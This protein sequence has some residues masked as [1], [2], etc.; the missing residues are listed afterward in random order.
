[1]ILCQFSPEKPCQGAQLTLEPRIMMIK[2]HG[3]KSIKNSQFILTSR[4]LSNLIVVTCFLTALSL[5]ARF[6]VGRSD[7]KATTF[8]G[9][10]SLNPDKIIDWNSEDE[11]IIEHQKNR[12]FATDIVLEEEFKLPKYSVPDLLYPVSFVEVDGLLKYSKKNNSLGLFLIPVGTGEPVYRIP[13]EARSKFDL[14]DSNGNPIDGTRRTVTAEEWNENTQR[15]AEELRAEAP[16]LTLASF[17]ETVLKIDQE[18][19]NEQNGTN[20]NQDLFDQIA[21]SLRVKIEATGG[22]GFTEEF[23]V[24]R[25]G[26][27]VVKGAYDEVVEELEL[28]DR[29]SEEKLDLSIAVQLANLQQR[30]GFTN[31]QKVIFDEVAVQLKTNVLEFQAANPA[32]DVDQ[33]NVEN[34][35]VKFC[36][37]KYVGDAQENNR[38]TCTNFAYELGWGIQSYMP[39]SYAN[40][41]KWSYQYALRN[42]RF[43]EDE[44]WE[45]VW[46]KQQQVEEPNPSEIGVKVVDRILRQSYYKDA[47]LDDTRNIYA[48]VGHTS[49]QEAI[50]KKLSD[51]TGVKVQTSIH[52]VSAY[53]GANGYTR[54]GFLEGGE[55]NN[56]YTATVKGVDQEA[57]N[58]NSKIW[59][60]LY[61][62]NPESYNF[63][64]NYE[65]DEFENVTLHRVFDFARGW[66]DTEWVNRPLNAAYKK[67]ATQLNMNLTAEQLSEV[68]KRPYYR[69]LQD[70]PIFGLY[71]F[72]GVTNQLNVALNVPL[73]R[74]YL[75]KI[76]GSD[77][78]EKIFTKA[79][80]RW[81]FILKKE[82]IPEEVLPQ[83]DLSVLASKLDKLVPLWE[84]KG[85]LTDIHQYSEANPLNPDLNNDSKP[86]K[87]VDGV[88][89]A[90]ELAPKQAEE[91]NTVGLGLAWVPQTTADI[92]S[93]LIEIYVPFQKTRSLITTGV[94]LGFQ[95]EH[96]RRTGITKESYMGFSMPIITKM[97]EL[98][99]S[100]A[101]FQKAAQADGSLRELTPDERKSILDPY[102]A[103]NKAGLKAMLSKPTEDERGRDITPTPEEVEATLNL[104]WEGKDQVVGIRASVEKAQPAT[105]AVQVPAALAE[106]KTDLSSEEL[107]A[108]AKELPG[109][110][111]KLAAWKIFK[112]YAK[113][114]IQKANQLPVAIEDALLAHMQ[115]KKYV[116]FY[117]RPG[118]LQSMSLGVWP[119]NPHVLLRSVG[120]IIAEDATQ[121]TQNLADY[122]YRNEKFVASNA[123]LVDEF[124]NTP[125]TDDEINAYKKRVYSPS[126]LGRPLPTPPGVRLRR[127]TS[128]FVAP[129]SYEADS[130]FAVRALNRL[131]SG[132][133][134][135]KTPSKIKR[136]KKA[137]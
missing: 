64:S 35:L 3:A 59:A 88:E 10:V 62:E 9:P 82:G 125:V 67:Y 81:L 4:F 72:E 91:V 65:F 129:S 32:A 37:D 136:T 22:E 42:Q 133:K 112:P 38:D 135:E 75:K 124:I 114:V 68:E 126:I 45:K 137:K 11:E 117:S 130:Q 40:N 90:Y 123:R 87:L 97:F 58:L 57:V 93:D 131:K 77:A 60:K 2:S 110:A 26:R 80:E 44:F 8:E 46:E 78:G 34:A 118:L 121:S 55:P 109:N 83:Y 43:N 100:M 41:L 50:Y 5:Q 28:R 76:F 127:D 89:V 116:K 119:T 36:E 86:V 74:K 48:M 69:W 111:L 29:L 20:P 52:H 49:A 120:T 98:E 51:L 39:K 107:Q 85:T 96:G 132:L 17:N 16:L 12:L 71:C 84:L 66:I 33:S 128:D 102:L 115:K 21:G 70:D 25:R 106:L 56:L 7:F 63:S 1:M 61:Y 13:D 92:L 134:P 53:Y 113:A 54:R 19:K 103:K 24:G 14:R 108:A 104:L 6:D 101:L 27:P 122:D 23:I 99:A 47:A 95:K 79:N 105:V 18:Q 15:A 31:E 30:E 94:I 73:T